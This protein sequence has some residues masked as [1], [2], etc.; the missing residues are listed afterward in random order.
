MLRVCIYSGTVKEFW[1]SHTDTLAFRVCSEDE[2]LALMAYALDSGYV[3]SIDAI[4][5]DDGG[6]DEP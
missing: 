2:V 5:D 6:G 1:D 3:M 4:E